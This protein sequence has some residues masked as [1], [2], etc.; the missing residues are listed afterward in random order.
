MAYYLAADFGGTVIKTRI[1]DET[2]TFCSPIR[3]FPSHAAKD[4]D[5]LLA[6][7]THV[8]NTALSDADDPQSVR[9]P[10]VRYTV[11]SP[12][13]PERSAGPLRR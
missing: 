1:L 3:T 9:L 4:A 12:A 10:G 5:T 6:H 7:F 13:F 2:G 8:L 11:P